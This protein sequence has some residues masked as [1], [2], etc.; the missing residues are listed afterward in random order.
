MKEIGF[1]KID[2]VDGSEGMLQVVRK[3]NLYEDTRK[4]V[5]GVDAFPEDLYSQYDAVLS[6]G[7][8]HEGHFPKETFDYM[9]KCAKVGAIIIFS[10]HEHYLEEGN[11]MEYVP[12]MK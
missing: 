6:A 5:I 2:A 10:M 7:C 11:V 9:I 4:V 1:E 8:F 3:E 12:K